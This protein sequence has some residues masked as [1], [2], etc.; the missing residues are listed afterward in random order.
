MCIHLASVLESSKH[1]EKVDLVF[2]LDSYPGVMDWY[3]YFISIAWRIE[4][5]PI[6]YVY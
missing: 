4:R 3:Y 5:Y 1:F 2:F 6:I